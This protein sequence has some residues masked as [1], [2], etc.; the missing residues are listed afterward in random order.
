MSVAASINILLRGNTKDLDSKLAAVE[1]KFKAFASMFS[2]SFF[3]VDTFKEQFE[4]IEKLEK[5]ASD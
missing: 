3:S 5:S 2:T 1:K 4:A